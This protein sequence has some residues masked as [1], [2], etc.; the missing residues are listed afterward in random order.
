[1]WNGLWAGD[2][3]LS[4]PGGAGSTYEPQPI[5]DR[6]MGLGFPHGVGRYQPGLYPRVRPQVVGVIDVWMD[7]DPGI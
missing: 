4:S 2:G 3:T 6:P 5:R 7:S 1:M